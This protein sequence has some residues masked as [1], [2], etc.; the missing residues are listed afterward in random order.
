MIEVTQEGDDTYIVTVGTREPL[1]Y[2]DHWAVVKLAKNTSLQRRFINAFRAKKC[3]LLF[4]S[5]NIVEIGRKL[6]ELP[7][8]SSFF[9][10]IGTDWCLVDVNAPA[11][12]EREKQRSASTMPPNF[13]EKGLR[14][15]YPYI[16]SQTLTLSKIAELVDG[17]KAEY[18]A[19]YDRL[20]SFAQQL[21]ATREA[22][23]QKASGINLEA[24][25]SSFYD[26]DKPTSYVYHSLMRKVLEG[27]WRLTKNH[28]SDLQHATAALS[29]ANFT[30][31]DKH[32]CQLA[33]DSL[34]EIPRIKDRVFRDT[35]KDIE[36][37]LST[38]ENIE[39]IEG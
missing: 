28:I 24:Y 3:T 21:M 10:E 36:K 1:I 31:L 35:P 15:Y 16:H 17:H 12:I 37:F 34:K 20:E 18:D 8:I 5:L 2:L 6:Y 29:Y 38:L 4:S 22:I 9:E 7:L 13:D 11:V 33:K 26:P 27:D 39:L 25:K 14:S 32:W 19:T 30:L 23:R